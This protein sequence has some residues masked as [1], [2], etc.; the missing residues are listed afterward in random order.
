MR[1]T[2]T[3]AP[4]PLTG[5][6][7]GEG[8]VA[9]GQFHGQ[10]PPTLTLPRQG[11]GKFLYM[12]LLCICAVLLTACSTTR[13]VLDMGKTVAGTSLET[14]SSTV[15]ISFRSPEK[16]M[17]ARGVMVYQQPDNLR[18]VVLTPFGTTA[19]EAFLVGDQLTLLYASKG[20]AFNGPLSQIPA[21]V[22]QRGWGMIRWVLAGSLPS[23]KDGV[24]QRPWLDGIETV[25]V[26][27]GL[28][29]EK[30]L[31]TGEKV[32]YSRHTIV[33]GLVL[34]QELVMENTEGDRIRLLL[35]EPEVNVALPE[36]A[37]VPRLDG[38]LLLPLSAL[39]GS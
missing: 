9:T 3:I 4:P 5:G 37:F 33:A 36:N 25:T 18:L 20:V 23:D 11:G 2:Y 7:W 30:K 27:D 13:P 26:K 35:E 1:L 34:A 15:S 28:L 19:L 16:N 24:Y 31:T 17:S 21:D 6:G 14:I 8:E 38:L 32:T 10:F 12:L 29:M 39:K 22:G